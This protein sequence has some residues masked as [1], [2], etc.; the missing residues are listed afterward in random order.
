MFVPAKMFL[1]K[2]VGIH[3]EQLQSFEIALRQAGIQFFNIV[4]VS[5][6]MPP[7]CAIISR[8]KGL[9]L[10]QPGQITFCVIS[11]AASN[12]PRRQIAASIGVAVPADK[13]MYGYLSEH[14]AYGETA[15]E[16]GE[17]AEN[18]AAAMLASTL[19]L[20]FDEDESWDNKRQI[21]TISGKIVR[22]RNITQSA[23]V[24]KDGKWKTVIAAAVLLP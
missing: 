20:E 10:L 5:S 22:S 14:H 15:D 3:R 1:T 6:I 4:S 12:E 23:E 17:Y 21:W 18:L 16:A 7:K 24:G 2:G 19:G 9:G 13:D 8:E 11:K